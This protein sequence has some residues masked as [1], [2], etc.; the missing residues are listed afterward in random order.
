M[1]YH[2]MNRNTKL[3]GCDLCGKHGFPSII[4][5]RNVDHCFGCWERVSKAKG[6]ETEKGLYLSSLKKEVKFCIALN[7]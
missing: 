3:Y 6:E 2:D 1:R 4:N 5:V 7:Q